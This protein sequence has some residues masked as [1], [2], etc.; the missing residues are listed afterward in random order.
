MKV[1]LGNEYGILV[2]SETRVLLRAASSLLSALNEGWGVYHS[3]HEPR[4]MTRNSRIWYQR[5]FLQRFMWSTVE[6]M[7]IESCMY[8][9]EASSCLEVWAEKHHIKSITV[10]MNINLGSTQQT[11]TYYVTKKLFYNGAYDLQ[12]N[13]W[14]CSVKC[15]LMR[16]TW[17]YEWELRTAISSLSRCVWA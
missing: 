1:S 12:S 11:V 16:P 6:L 7:K 13:S 2:E 8:V 17:S 3:E 14:R 5:A 4:F 9:A 15:A 10:S